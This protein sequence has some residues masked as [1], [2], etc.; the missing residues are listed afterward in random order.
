VATFLDKF[1]WGLLSARGVPIGDR[2]FSSIQ[3]FSEGRAGGEIGGRWG[4]V[5]RDGSLRILPRYIGEQVGSFH[6]DRA[7]VR[8]RDGLTFITPGAEIV[9]L[10]SF[11]AVRDFSESRAA[12]K[13]G[14]LWGYINWWGQVVIQPQFEEAR[15]FHEGVAIVN[16]GGSWGG[17]K[18]DGSVAVDFRFRGEQPLSDFSEGLACF[19]ENGLMGYLDH[20][21]AV[22]IPARWRSACL[23]FQGKAIVT[24]AKGFLHQID[25]SGKELAEL[26]VGYVVGAGKPKDRYSPARFGLYPS[27]AKGERLFVEDMAFQPEFVE[28]WAMASLK[29]EDTTGSHYQS[30]YFDGKDIFVTRGRRITLTSRSKKEVLGRDAKTPTIQPEFDVGDTALVAPLDL[31]EAKPGARR[32]NSLGMSLRWVPSGNFLMGSPENQEVR[33]PDEGP[34]HRVTFSQGFWMGETEVT[35][36]QYQRVMGRDLSQFPGENRPVDSLSWKDAVEFCSALTDLDRKLGGLAEGWSYRLPSESEWEYAVRAG[37]TEERYEYFDAVAWTNWNHATR[38]EVV[39]R[40]LPNA[41]GLYDMLGNVWEWTADYKHMGYE[42]APTDGSAW[43]QGG[44]PGHR[45]LRGGGCNDDPDA[46]RAAF[47]FRGRPT[48]RGEFFGVRV[49][50]APVAQ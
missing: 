47:R 48:E 3:D 5:T 4:F 15:D 11:E 10:R 38:T 49:V 44:D 25:A 1:G 6:E 9:S 33:W 17:V 31:K 2:R 36:E 32:V 23:F 41:W 35:Q 20:S 22:K 29:T 19:Q 8:T 7:W 39:G 40:K 28:G 13:I 43:V 50:A 14:G 46:S 37:T 27:N 21:G 30:G 34:Q 24:D 26:D 16:K 12:V 42:G 18:H 45:V